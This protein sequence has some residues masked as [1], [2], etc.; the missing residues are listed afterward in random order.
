[1]LTVPPEVD[2]YID[3][4]VIIKN[5]YDVNALNYPVFRYTHLRQSLWLLLYKLGEKERKLNKLFCFDRLKN[6]DDKVIANISKLARLHQA[7]VIPLLDQID[8]WAC[9]E[10]NFE[11]KKAWEPFYQYFLPSLNVDQCYW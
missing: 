4:G 2:F 6:S 5:L 8:Q 11:D 1:V 7:K 10:K 9:A 3:V